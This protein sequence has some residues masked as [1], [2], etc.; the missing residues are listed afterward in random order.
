MK[1]QEPKILYKNIIINNDNIDDF[2]E[3]PY[4]G[5]FC[6]STNTITIFQYTISNDIP[7]PKK[8]DAKSIAKDATDGHDGVIIHEKQHWRNH[9]LVP[10]FSEFCFM[11]YY[12]EISL[13]CLDEISAITAQILYDTPK[14]K[15]MGISQETVACSMLESTYYFQNYYFQ[16]YISRFVSEILENHH[17]DI[18][19]TTPKKAFAYLKRL[20]HTYKTCPTELFDKRF[21]DTVKGFFTYDDNCILNDKISSSTKNVWDTV[22]MNLSQIK[23]DSLVETFRMIN[24][25][26]KPNNT[27]HKKR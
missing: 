27:P 12:Q 23:Q 1:H 9:I 5:V 19:A 11:N 26:L 22:K 18:R 10:K 15:Q 20:Q 25:I 24:K 14:Y 6:A 7:E 21:H 8:S 4:G 2:L 3:N 13:L 16:D 17:L